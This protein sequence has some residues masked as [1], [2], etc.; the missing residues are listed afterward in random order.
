MNVLACQQSQLKAS[1]PPVT[2]QT[3]A[4]EGAE[5]QAEVHL[6]CQYLKETLSEKD[7]LTQKAALAI[8]MPFQELQL[9]IFM[10]PPVHFFHTKVMPKRRGFLNTIRKTH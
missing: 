1:L 5:V 4:G 6:V 2:P 3:G 9:L 8:L 7:H 10:L